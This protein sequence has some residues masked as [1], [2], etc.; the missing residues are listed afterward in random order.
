MYKITY[1]KHCRK[2]CNS[3]KH[4]NLEI[5]TQINLDLVCYYRSDYYII[6]NFVSRLLFS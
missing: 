1:K 4:I 5:L 2:K 3:L 6:K